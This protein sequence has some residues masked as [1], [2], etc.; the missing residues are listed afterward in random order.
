MD[1]INYLQEE[2]SYQNLEDFQQQKI[3][4]FKNQLLQY[5]E[6]GG[7]SLLLPAL[8]LVRKGQELF[9][10]GSE[11]IK[12]LSEIAG[13]GS[14]TGEGLLGNA[15]DVGEGLLN[16]ATGMGEGL[17]GKATGM[18]EGLLGK[19]GDLGKISDVMNFSKM[20]NTVE[21]DLSASV[22]SIGGRLS[23]KMMTNAFERDPELDIADANQS[24]GLID[25]FQSV[26]RG[27]QNPIESVSQNIGNIGENV[28]KTAEDIGGGLLG[29]ASEM[30]SGLLGKV[31]EISENVAKTAG[32]VGEGVSEGLGALGEVGGALGEM[33]GPLGIVAM[34]GSGIA[35]LVESFRKAPTPVAYE[36]PALE[37]GV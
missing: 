21:N 34:A 1:L 26:F 27:G 32:E 37:I 20:A 35:D 28:A 9:K 31:G 19:V 12:G 16:K 10:S 7:E 14:G 13:K 23:N 29:K 5:R 22:R 11:A 30:G 6:E 3:E 33:L 15:L 4:A 25:K 17:L 24:A 36:A 2:G 18:G 8:E